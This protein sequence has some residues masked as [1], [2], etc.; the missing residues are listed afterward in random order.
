M[1]FAS[2]GFFTMLRTTS[3]STAR[4]PK[5]RMSLLTSCSMNVLRRL[6]IRSWM[7]ATTLRLCA[8][9]FVPCGALAS[10]R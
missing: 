1:D 2:L 8:R 4:K 10:L 3:A 7:R 5:R 9:S 6:A